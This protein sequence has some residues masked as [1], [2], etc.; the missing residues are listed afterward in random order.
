METPA[1]RI[2]GGRSSLGPVKNTSPK[3]GRY[4]PECL[5]S[6]NASFEIPD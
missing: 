5:D 3:L 2:G 6:F 1:L 4:V